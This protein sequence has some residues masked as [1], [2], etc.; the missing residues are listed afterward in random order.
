MQ[1]I[2]ERY[3]IPKIQLYIQPFHSPNLFKLK[4]ELCLVIAVKIKT[5]VFNIARCR[6]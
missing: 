3:V 4:E 6:F 5:D 1:I 2:S